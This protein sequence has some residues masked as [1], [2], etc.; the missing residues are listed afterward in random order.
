MKS[1]IF[2]AS[3][4]MFA[5]PAMAQGH[6]A[7]A[8]PSAPVF[9]GGG[10]GGYGGGISFGSFALGTPSSSPTVHDQVVFAHGSEATF[11]PTRFVSYS[12]A[13]KLGKEALAYRPKT[14]AEVSAEYRAEKAK[15][16]AQKK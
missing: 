6:G 13:L 16:A 15:I 8:A 1:A 9:S 5:L 4:L 2:A 12:E 14:V 7:A 3:I 10:G 11:V